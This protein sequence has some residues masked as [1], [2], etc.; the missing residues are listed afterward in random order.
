VDVLLNIKEKAF[1]EYRRGM[2]LDGLQTAA[3][4]ATLPQPFLVLYEW[5]VLRAARVHQ[6][7][8]AGVHGGAALHQALHDIIRRLGA[9]TT[10]LA[11][12]AHA[13]A[14]SCALWVGWWMVRRRNPWLKN[15]RKP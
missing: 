15:Y 5:F 2:N 11:D 10:F 3:I 12:S 13:A 4:L 9:A 7:L 1:D 14:F 6:V 8:V